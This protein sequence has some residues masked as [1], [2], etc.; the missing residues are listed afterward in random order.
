MPPGFLAS[1]L[2][3]APV[4]AVSACPPSPSPPTRLAAASGN[5][6]DHVPG[7]P[8]FDPHDAGQL[9]NVMQQLATAGNTADAETQ[10]AW[11]RQ[12]AEPAY[13]S[14]LDTLL[15]ELDR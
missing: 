13:R 9:Q 6:C 2:A 5:R 10:R 8:R 12:F 14:R 11:A 4:R 15:K 7:A 3:S 1:P